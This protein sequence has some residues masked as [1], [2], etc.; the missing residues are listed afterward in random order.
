M[1]ERGIVPRQVTEPHR[2]NPQRYSED[3]STDDSED[4]QN[5]VDVDI[6][7]TAEPGHGRMI[8]GSEPDLESLCG[9]PQRGIV[10]P[11]S[12]S[13]RLIRQPSVTAQR[14]RGR[15]CVRCRAPQH[16]WSLYGSRS[17]SG[18]YAMVESAETVAHRS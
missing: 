8:V 12:S 5:R 4:R 1:P 7:K 3:D 6:A 9:L 13:Y 16:H 15:G 17:S 10:I 11:P 14:R 2:P 18:T